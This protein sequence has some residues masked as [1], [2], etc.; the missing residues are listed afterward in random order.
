MKARWDSM[1]TERMR[2]GTSFSFVFVLTRCGCWFFCFSWHSFLAVDVRSLSPFS[3]RVW[4]IINRECETSDFLAVSLWSVDQVSCR[5]LEFAWRTNWIWTT[6][7][8][9]DVRAEKNHGRAIAVLQLSSRSISSGNNRRN[10]KNKL[11]SMTL[12]LR[13]TLLVLLFL[14][15]FTPTQSIVFFSMINIRWLLLLF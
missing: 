2:F 12:S 5:S 8:S 6:P 9:R 15:E 14:S 4:S 7:S 11:P 3:I 13:L 1:L 10:R